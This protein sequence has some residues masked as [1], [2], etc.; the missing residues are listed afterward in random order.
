[1]STGR[2]EFFTSHCSLSS[3]IGKFV[4]VHP[5]NLDHHLYEDIYSMVDQFAD[6]DSA[7][8]KIDDSNCYELALS[9]C[10]YGYDYTVVLTNVYH[11][12]LGNIE[13]GAT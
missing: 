7:L 9:F 1:M 13:G 8:R 10:S 11:C 4:Q 12:F 5:L 3:E 2:L 6:L